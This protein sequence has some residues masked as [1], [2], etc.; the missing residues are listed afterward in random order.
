MWSARDLHL[1]YQP[2]RPDLL[3]CDSINLAT[4]KPQKEAPR[5]VRMTGLKDS[6]FSH[7][8]CTTLQHPVTYMNRQKSAW[9]CWK[10][11][12]PTF[13][14]TEWPN[15]WMN[16]TR[17]CVASRDCH[18]NFF[19]GPQYRNSN[20]RSSGIA[21]LE[22]WHRIH[23]VLLN[24]LQVTCQCPCRR[25]QPWRQFSSLRAS[26]CTAE[27]IYWSHNWKIRNMTRCLTGLNIITIQ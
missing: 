20:L 16:N 7:H 1:A 11:S 13:T 23:G 10:E 4:L 22:M 6:P 2:H 26:R 27:C 5:M 17:K 8:F 15:Y 3:V 9:C 24:D 18:R 25:P 19:L 14:S 12:P 21:R